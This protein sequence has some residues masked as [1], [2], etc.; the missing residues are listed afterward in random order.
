[1]FLQVMMDNVRDVFSRLCVF[2][3]VCFPLVVQ[4]QTL[5]EM[6]NWV[7]IWC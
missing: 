5:S 3:L 4:K 6:G 2:C 1:M 7:V